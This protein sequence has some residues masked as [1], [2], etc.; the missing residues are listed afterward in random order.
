MVRILVS[1]SSRSAC[2]PGSDTTVSPSATI[3][4]QS[5]NGPVCAPTLMTKNQTNMVNPTYASRPTHSHL[6]GWK[7]IGL[8]ILFI[9]CV[10]TRVLH[11]FAVGNFERGAGRE[12]EEIARN[13]IEGRGYA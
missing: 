13:L 12:S 2:V 3:V 7:R 4:Q 10:G 9:L 5:S 8:A 11:V 6:S 1:R